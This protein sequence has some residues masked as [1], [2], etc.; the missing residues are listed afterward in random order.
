MSHDD[1][2]F[3]GMDTHTEYTGV[4]YILE[5]RENTPQYLGK[6]NTRKLAVEKMVRQFQSK[7]PKATLYFVYE[8]GPCGYWLYR[9]ISK[10]WH[11]C[12]I[13]APSLVPKKP[14][15]HVKIDKRDSLDLAFSDPP[16]NFDT[17]VNFKFF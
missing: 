1:I 11:D 12:F 2:V 15:D 13:V 5:D 9:L 4:S 14:G 3:I 17:K 6:I 16:L 8:A 7:Y 10:L